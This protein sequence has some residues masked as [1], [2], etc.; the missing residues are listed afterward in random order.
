MVLQ[1]PKE[2]W[3]KTKQNKTK[4]TK[5]KPSKKALNHVYY[6]FSNIKYDDT[7]CCRK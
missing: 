4:Q 6:I 5:K 7:I 2:D 1:F 3:E